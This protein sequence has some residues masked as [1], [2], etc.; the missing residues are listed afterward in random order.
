MNLRLEIRSRGGW[1]GRA[2]YGGAVVGALGALALCAPARAAGAG[3]AAATF[4]PGPPPTLAGFTVTVYTSRSPNARALDDGTPVTLCYFNAA[5]GAQAPISAAVGVGGVLTVPPPPIPPGA[6]QL[7]GSVIVKTVAFGDTP[8]IIWYDSGWTSVT[9]A[10]KIDP[11][12]LP[13]PGG[14][15]H[16]FFDLSFSPVQMGNSSVLFGARS[17]NVL[18]SGLDVRYSSSPSG[19]GLFDV[20]VNGSDSFVQFDDAN[21][22]RMSL[23]DG[24]VL[25]QIG[26]SGGGGGGGGGAG[27]GN[28]GV[29]NL[30]GL[31]MSGL[32]SYEP[33]SN[34][35]SAI[36]MPT[37]TGQFTA[38]ATSQVP[39]PGV[40]S[41]FAV[42]G[43]AAW[44]G[45]RRRPVVSLT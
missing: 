39:G 18:S 14:S 35:T 43:L 25:G 26:L 20:I 45:R 32:W 8:P 19:P 4:T 21:F 28:S 42:A 23:V 41:V 12:G 11:I 1:R 33:A 40:L 34:Y 37:S 3:S 7:G 27:V 36:M 15:Q 2:V 24:T 9:P 29:L 17:L 10:I 30:P 22:T 16:W 13:T 5:G 6:T 31:G 44:S 38:L